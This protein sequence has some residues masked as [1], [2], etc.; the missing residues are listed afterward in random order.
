MLSFENVAGW[1][2]LVLLPRVP[3][4]RQNIVCAAGKCF[5][6]VHCAQKDGLPPLKVSGTQ[7]KCLGGLESIFAA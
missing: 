6:T 2:M 3:A 1:A 5:Y 7:L 4:L